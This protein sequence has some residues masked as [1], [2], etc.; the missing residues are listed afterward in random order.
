MENEINHR[1]K[2]KLVATR[3]LKFAQKARSRR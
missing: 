2:H 1:E 3:G